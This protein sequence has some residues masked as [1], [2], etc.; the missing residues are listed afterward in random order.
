[1]LKEVDLSSDPAAFWR[2]LLACC[3]TK[4]R[5]VQIALEILSFPASCAAVERSFSCVRHVH[6]WQRNRLAPKTL[7]NLVYIYLNS[8][9]L[10]K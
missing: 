9:A 2:R 6:T 8:R 3:G 5:I 1:M 4:R 10:A 7:N